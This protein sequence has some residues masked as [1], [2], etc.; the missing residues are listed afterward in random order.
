MARAVG[1]EMTRQHLIVYTVDKVEGN[2]RSGH[3]FIEYFKGRDDTHIS[4]RG[5]PC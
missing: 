3:N 2:Q 5:T 4:P 1:E